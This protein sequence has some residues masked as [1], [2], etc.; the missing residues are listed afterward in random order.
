MNEQKDDEVAIKLKVCPIC[1]VPI[2]KNLRYGTSIKQ[3]LE[4]IEI[5]K[6]KIQGSAGEIST[7]QEQL[8]ALLKS[9]T[10]FHQLRPEEFLILQEKLAQKNLSVKDLGLVENSIRFYDHLANLE[11]SLEKVHCGEQQSVRTRLEQVHEWLA[12]KRLSF[13]SQELSDLQSEIQRLT[14]L[15]NLLMRCKMAEKVK[16]S[17]AEEV[18]SIRNILEKTSK[19]TQ[20]DEQLV[21]KKMDALKTT[22]PCSGLGISDEERVQ[23]V[24][25]MGVPRGHWFKCPNGHIYVITECGGAM[26]RS[27]CPECQEVI[28]GENH[29]LERS[30]HLASEMD[31]AQHPAWSNTANNFMNFEEI[32]RMM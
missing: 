22:L 20:E 28:G 19:F 3:R 2:R 6:E 32:H 8:K 12:K 11:G 7:S 9:K 21:Q 31:G 29:T 15:V 10:L 17:I 30:N 23:I 16:G 14:Y 27:T 13:S 5:V 25:A 4:E 18:S 24:T 26:Q 1:Q